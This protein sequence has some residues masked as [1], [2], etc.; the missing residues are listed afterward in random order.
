MIKS[1]SFIP[2]PAPLPSLPVDKSCALIQLQEVTKVFKTSAGEF[3]ALRDI[4]LCFGEGE[5]VSIL[6]KSGSGKS[7]LINMITGIDH[8][9]SGVVRVGDTDVHHLSEG[10]LAVWRGKTMGIVFQ[11]FQLL[12]MLTVLENTMLPMDFCN[13]Y[14]NGERESRARELLGMVGLQDE[15]DKLP[16]ALSGG[17][18]QTAAIARALANDPPLI[19]A[20]EPTGNLD[21]RTA[22]N[23][24]GI[25]CDLAEKGKTIIIVT[26]DP[27]LTRRTSRQ[28]YISDGYL[29]NEFVS[30]ALADLPHSQMLK[31]SRQGNTRSFETGA[32]IARREA[33]STGLHVIT[34]GLVE[35]HRVDAQNGDQLVDY[36]NPGQYFSELDFQE[37]AACDLRFS[38]SP[39]EPV[40]TLWLES[41]AFRELLADSQRAQ[42]KLMQQAQERSLQYCS[43]TARVGG[44]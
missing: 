15:A 6:G 38:V 18:Q 28:V 23:V 22:E 27:N 8:P 35:V 24:L 4:N 42:R 34:H 10:R 41:A 11:F 43:G 3:T 30:Q 20:D 33:P 25:F 36:L 44:D 14:A 19:I 13:M 29:I 17:Q 7:T 21:S 5:F 31:I 32:L 26:H 12:P 37:S 39:Y 9:T 16:A 40:E 2:T 1:S